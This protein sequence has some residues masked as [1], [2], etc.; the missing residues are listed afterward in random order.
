MLRRFSLWLISFYQ[1]YLSPLKGPTCRFYPTCS[2]YAAE[3]IRRYGFRTGWI[4]A[5]RRILKCHP[6][7]SGGYDPLPDFHENKKIKS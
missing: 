1:N 4:L 2:I 6:W 5:I 3:A 7:N